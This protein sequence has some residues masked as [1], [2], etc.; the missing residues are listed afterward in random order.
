MKLLRRAV[1]LDDRLTALAEAARAARGRLPDHVVDRAR[2]V[3]ERA[4]ERRGL[5]VEHTVVALAGATGGGKSS[6]FNLLTGARLAEVGVTRPTTATARAA[7]WDGA[8]AG[9]LLDWLGVTQRHEIAGEP[10][11]LVLLDLPDHDSIEVSHRLEADRLVDLVDLLV[12][13]V[14]PQKY[15][16]AALHERYLRQLARHGD[17]TLVVLNQVDRLAP[18]AVDRCLADLRRLL[19]ADG[20]SQA[21]VLGV[22][23]RTGAG[24]A[25]LRAALADRVARRRSW[26]DRLAADTATAAVALARAA[27]GNG[28]SAGHELPPVV[29]SGRIE[30]LE[31]PLTAALMDAAAV[32]TVVEAVARAHRHRSIIAT[33]WPVTRWVRRLRPDPLRRLGLVDERWTGGAAER[34]AEA[35]LREAG[36]PGSDGSGGAVREGAVRRSSLPGA[37]VVQ[38]SR[39]DTAIRNLAH[40]A[41]DGLPE[42]WSAAVRRAAR[43]RAREL[44]DRLDRAVAGAAF[45]RRPRWWGP[46]AA[47]QWLLIAAAIAGALWLAGLF[48]LDYLRLPEPPVPTLGELPW[49]TVLLVGGGLAGVPLA[50][51]FRVAAWLG[52]RRRGRRA[53][54]V[55]R[56]SVAE[57]GRELVVAPVREEVDRY[58]R[59]ADAVRSA[60]G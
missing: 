29:A 11:G 52:G 10:S 41:A 13:V 49:P 20:L 14:D 23:A 45:G 50:L 57:T 59:F 38:R 44:P 26:A 24:V 37:S 21:S 30:R 51:L 25:E 22:S 36:R 53:L 9:P 16:D 55:L 19:D 35:A 39:T 17:V 54:R 32:P 4:G 47:L 3:V 8:G 7:V 60:S 58:R 31:K 33:G 12:W 2:T 27:Y 34:E 28:T 40:A 46:A 18:S 43:S 42:E 1:P 15:A 48:A 5:S 6:L 56:A